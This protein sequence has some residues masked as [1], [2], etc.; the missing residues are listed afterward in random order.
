VRL[1]RQLPWFLRNVALKILLRLRLRPV[2]R[3]CG[4]D[5]PY[6]PY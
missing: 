1:L 5:S 2:A 4:H 3:L 6:D